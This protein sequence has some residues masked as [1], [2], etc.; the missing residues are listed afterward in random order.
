M[1]QIN[2]LGIIYLVI[3]LFFFAIGEIKVNSQLKDPLTTCVAFLIIWM[4][5][6]PL[7]FVRAI[8]GKK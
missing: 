7:I 2:I 1:I 8:W 4:S 3:G 5:W 6:V